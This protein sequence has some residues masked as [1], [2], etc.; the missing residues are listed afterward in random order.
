MGSRRKNKQ[1]RERAEERR[2]E[3]SWK[4]MTERMKEGRDRNGKLKSERL[5]RDADS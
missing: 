2:G 4:K 3:E 5:V 1:S